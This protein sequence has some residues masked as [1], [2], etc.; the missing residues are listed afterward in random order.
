MP[1]FQNSLASFWQRCDSVNYRQLHV[2]LK[3]PYGVVVVPQPQDR[4]AGGIGGGLRRS[5][6]RSSFRHSAV[7]Q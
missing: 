5:E 4:I 2:D 6:R 3:V 7:K 1:T